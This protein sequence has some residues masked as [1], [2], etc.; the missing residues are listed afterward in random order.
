MPDPAPR[1]VADPTIVDDSG[2]VQDLP[3]D[4]DDDDDDDDTADEVD[5]NALP[6]DGGTASA[7]ALTPASAPTPGSAPTPPPAPIDLGQPAP[8]G[9]TTP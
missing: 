7:P 9:G 3:D 4:D 2:T 6:D 1:D 8:V 5:A